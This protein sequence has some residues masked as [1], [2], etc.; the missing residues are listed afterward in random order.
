[1][2]AMELGRDA[3]S[4]L[5]FSGGDDHVGADR[6]QLIRDGEPVP[7]GRTR[8]E[9]DAT[10][11]PEEI[12][13]RRR[14]SKAARWGT[15]FKL[16]LPPKAF[17]GSSGFGGTV[18]SMANALPSGWKQSKGRLRCSYQF[19]DFVRAMT[20]LQEVAFLAES[21]EHHPDFTVHW[22]TVDFLVWSHDVD[23]VTDR[24]RKLVA[25]IA[26]IAKRHEAKTG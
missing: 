23:A 7:A 3:N 18:R 24:D 15:D 16:T 9:R 1:M 17:R 25:G 20:F 10:L 26:K 8:H 21:R 12:L 6:G 2:F 22:N 4:V 13:D 5:L 11:E 14:A 19:R